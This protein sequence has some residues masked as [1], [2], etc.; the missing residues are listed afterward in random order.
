MTRIER[1]GPWDRFLLSVVVLVAIYAAALVVFGLAIGDTIFDPLGFGPDD[2][3][4]ET[5]TS[6]TYVQLIF[7]VLGAVIVGW[8]ATIAGL[9]VGPLARREP[10][11][12]NT[13]A[14]A[15][16]AWFVLDTGAS[17]L[18]GFVGHAAFN[19]GF[20]VALAAPLVMIRRELQTARRNPS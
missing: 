6:R 17:L 7:A 19:V 1:L 20:A 11:A 12:W 13:I 9:V 10:W 14:G 2:G 16:T 4:I 18:L 5:A 8:M 15:A 3:E